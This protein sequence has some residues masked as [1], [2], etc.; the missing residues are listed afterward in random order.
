VLRVGLTGGIAAGKSVVAARLRELG[1]WV[2]D[3]DTLAREVVAPG[4]DGLAAVVAAFGDQ[5]LTPEGTLNRG[6]LGRRVFADAA[7]RARLE[8]IL[9]PRIRAASHTSEERAAASGAEVVVHDIPLLVETGQAEAFDVVVV[10]DAPV[11][12]R[13]DR[14]VRGRGMAEAAARARIGAQAD[15]ATRAA[16]ADVVLDG[17]GTVAHLQ[18]QV[19]ELWQSWVPDAR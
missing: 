18:Q 7:A 10:V 15:D 11:E 8:A 5:V 13:L 19:D 16:A 17:S 3:H 4:T 9:H 1:A 6:R 2:V 12:V 14:L